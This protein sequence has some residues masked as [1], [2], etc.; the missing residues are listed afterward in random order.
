MP[1]EEADEVLEWLWNDALLLLGRAVYLDEHP[2]RG[3]R[4]HDIL[5]DIAQRLM[6][7]APP[8]GLGITLPAAHATLL[9]AYQA[10]TR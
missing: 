6:I 2:W 1:L 10:L 7:A 5:H 3:Y 8:K 9:S 4:L